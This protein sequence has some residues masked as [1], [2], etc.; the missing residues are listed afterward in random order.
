LLY[1][2]NSVFFGNIENILNENKVPNGA[3]NWIDD[4]GERTRMKLAFIHCYNTL[5]KLTEK[6]VVNVY[7]EYNS[8]PDTAPPFSANMTTINAGIINSLNIYLGMV[9]DLMVCT[10]EFAKS[11]ELVVFNDRDKIIKGL[12]VLSPLVQQIMKNSL[13]GISKIIAHVNTKYQDGLNRHQDVKIISLTDNEFKFGEM[14][15]IDAMKLLVDTPIVQNQESQYST[16]DILTMILTC[17]NDYKSYMES[18][19]A[20]APFDLVLRTDSSYA[21]GYLQEYKNTTDIANLF[22]NVDVATMPYTMLDIPYFNIKLKKK[23]VDM[24]IHNTYYVHFYEDFSAITI[25]ILNT[26]K[27]SGNMGGEEYGKAFFDPDKIPEYSY[28]NEIIGNRG[29]EGQFNDGRIITKDNIAQ[30][31]RNMLLSKWVHNQYDFYEDDHLDKP[32]FKLETKDYVTQQAANEATKLYTKAMQTT[33][34]AKDALH[35]L[36]TIQTDVKTKVDRINSTLNVIVQPKR[37]P[38]SP[39]NDIRDITGAQLDGNVATYMKIIGDAIADSTGSKRS[40][41]VESIAKTIDSG[42]S[43]TYVQQIRVL[44]TDLTDVRQEAM[45]IKDDIEQKVSDTKN[46]LKTKADE[47]GAKISERLNTAAK[48]K[49]DE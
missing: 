16:D 44:E 20:A 40:E 33:N 14:T 26:D 8:D 32:E 47:L 21:K 4:I 35:E 30:Y 10:P 7:Q 49:V 15:F 3:F 22:G 36:K 2:N 5:G 13:D 43:K 38:S 46:L 6:Y 27:D 34:T 17:Y 1:N 42:A 37:L 39:K 25:L 19:G 9:Y 48:I 45:T 23:V 28:K 12:R 29:D 41:K 11:D 31:L 24:E 18:S